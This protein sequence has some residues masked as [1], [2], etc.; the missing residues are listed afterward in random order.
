MNLNEWIAAGKPNNT[1]V[2]VDC[3]EGMK[4][5]PD[6]S[7][8]IIITSPPYNIGKSVGYENG[9]YAFY[10]DNLEHYEYLDFMRAV[11]KECIR[12][13]RY[14]FYNFQMLSNNR[15]TYL[16]ILGEFKNQIKDIIIWHKKTAPPA[17]QPTCLSTAFEFVVV[18]AKP[19]L[20]VNR[21]FE[22]AFFN[23]RNEGE[24][25]QNVIYGN[26][27][28]IDELNDNTKADNAAAFPQ[29]FVRWFIDKFTQEGDLVLDPFMGT[30]TTG[31]VAKC[32]NRNW[33]GFEID[34][35]QTLRATEHIN[36]IHTLSEYIDKKDGGTKDETLHSFLRGGEGDI[37]EETQLQETERPEIKTDAG[38]QGNP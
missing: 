7:V 2:N 15:T 28:S 36:S 10:Q 32:A 6:N 33:L 24:C 13:S 38:S 8:D 23:N 30:G 31:L 3:V 26:N 22:R 27:N 17:A 1:I 18:F 19:E 5:M 37:V 21:S 16:M 20:A 35:T 29:Y 12:I 34:P 11:I 14:T 4:S 25:N 9:K